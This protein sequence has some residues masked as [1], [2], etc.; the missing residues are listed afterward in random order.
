MY[1]LSDRV[2]TARKPYDCDTRALWERA[3]LN[4]SDVKPVD[5]LIAQHAIKNNWVIEVGDRYRKVVYVEGGELQT[6]RGALL[7]DDICQRLDLFDE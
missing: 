4:E 2:Q 3:G 1:V 6:Y 5:W 7:M